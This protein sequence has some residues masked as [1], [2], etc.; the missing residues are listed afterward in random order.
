VP[1]LQERPEVEALSSIHDLDRLLKR[2]IERVMALLDIE[3]ASIILLDEERDELYVAKVAD[4]NRVGHEQRL[5]GVRF[6]ATQGIAGWVV[7]EGHSLIVPDVDHDP[8][9]YRGIDV[10]AG[11]RTRSILCVPLRTQGRIIG[12]LEGINKR[13]GSFTADDVRRLEAFAHQLAPVLEQAR[14]IQERSH[15]DLQQLIAEA[16]RPASRTVPFDTLIGESPKMQEVVRLV[17]RVRHTTATVLL[18]GERGT[19]KDLIARLLHDQGPRAQGPFIAVNC[20]ALPETQLE[21]ELFGDEREAGTGA[22]QRQPGRLELAAGGT[23]FLQEIGAMSRV[24]Q[25]KLLRVLQEQRFERVGGTETLTTDARIVAATSQD[26]ERLMAEGRFRRD[27][28]HR[29]NVYSIA[30]PPLRECREDL[31]ALTLHFLKR[32]S[33]KGRKEVLGMSEEAMEWLERYPWPGNVRE[34][35]EVIEGAVALW[36]GPTVSVQDLPQALREQSHAPGSNG[37]ALRLP[38]GGIDMRELEKDL[39]RQALE[40]AHQNKSQAA[41]LLGLSRTQLRARMQLYRLE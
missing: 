40:Q 31:R 37:D 1:R 20:A 10:H 5:R 19:G 25:T 8:R 35:E 7:R 3:S 22:T 9:V 27:L 29:L 33:H 21:A 14:A 39:I 16:E 28:Y 17:E 2:A 41:K 12:V 11:T 15:L 24:L 26:L 23:L 13:Q 6:P 34:L 38:P 4:E 30:L 32:S 18:T 36:Q